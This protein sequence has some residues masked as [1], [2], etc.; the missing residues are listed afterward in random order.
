LQ[1]VGSKIL[2]PSL[3]IQ[4]VTLQKTGYHNQFRIGI[5]FGF[6]ETLKQKAWQIGATGSHIP[7]CGYVGYNKENYQKITPTF[8]ETEILNTTSTKPETPAPGPECGHDIVPIVYGNQSNALQLPTVVEYK[9]I[10]IG[11]D[12]KQAALRTVDKTAMCNSSNEGIGTRPAMQNQFL[13]ML[14]LIPPEF[15]IQCLK[16]KQ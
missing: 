9:T 12:E 13:V 4:L 1:N 14:I 15:G 16:L 11:K 6:D 5:R 2:N 8:P 3:K 7:K 10:S